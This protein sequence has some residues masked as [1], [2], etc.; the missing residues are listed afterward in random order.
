METEKVQ[1]AMSGEGLRAGYTLYMRQG[2]MLQVT[3]WWK[4]L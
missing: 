1:K 2:S 4:G 3:D